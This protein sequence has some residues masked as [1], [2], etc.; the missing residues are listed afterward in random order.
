MAKVT[1]EY[2][3]QLRTK[4]DNLTGEFTAA[5]NKKAL[6][7]DDDSQKTLKDVKGLADFKRLKEDVKGTTDIARKKLDKGELINAK[8]SSGG[9]VEIK[10]MRAALNYLGGRVKPITVTHVYKTILVDKS[11]TKGGNAEWLDPS[12]RGKVYELQ[13]PSEEGLAVQLPNWHNGGRGLDRR[14]AGERVGRFCG[15][16]CPHLV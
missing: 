4:W 10:T 3:Y 15:V 13:L 5:Y 6:L 12:V 2:L 14:G 9:D 1:L 7:G 11:P 16:D 8:G